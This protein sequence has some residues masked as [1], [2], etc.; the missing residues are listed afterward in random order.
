[1]FCFLRCR[2]GSVG[3]D[4][5]RFRTRCQSEGDIDVRETNNSKL[6]FESFRSAPVT[7][8]FSEDESVFHSPDNESKLVDGDG[9]AVYKNEDIDLFSVKRRRSSQDRIEVQD[10]VDANENAEKRKISS[11]SDSATLA[12]RI[13]TERH[14]NGSV[15]SHSPS[16]DQS[17]TS[18]QKSSHVWSAW[19]YDSTTPR[20]AC[21][22]RNTTSLRSSHSSS[23][24]SREGQGKAI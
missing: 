16:V 3:S 4:G 11:A 21:V 7:P 18:K 1:M 17:S 13:K 22:S 20:S 6:E 9:C 5:I 19:E 10:N 15:V 14:V 24:E 23:S 8:V 2:N 12:K